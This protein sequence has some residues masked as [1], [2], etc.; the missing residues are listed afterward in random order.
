VGFSGQASFTY[1]AFDGLLASNVATVTVLV[2]N[3]APVAVNDNATTPQNVPVV[4]NLAA[5]DYDPDGAIIPATL[6]IVDN[7]NQGGT[8]VNNLNGTVL[9]TPRRNFRGTDLFTYTV[10]DNLNAVSNKATVRVDVVR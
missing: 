8:V 10:R 2:G 5:N 1:T 4:I 3:Q 7:P 9:F 6:V